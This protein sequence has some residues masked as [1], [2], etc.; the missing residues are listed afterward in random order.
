MPK[1]AYAA[2]D[3]NGSSVEGFTKADTVGAAR[4]H[5][6]DQNLYPVKIEEKRGA[7]QF[8]LTTVKVKKKGRGEGAAGGRLAGMGAGV[9]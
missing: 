9:N 5:L 7:L 6:L 4:A 1:F 3:S 2:I 8:E